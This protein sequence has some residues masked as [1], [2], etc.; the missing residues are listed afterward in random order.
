MWFVLFHPHV[1]H[2]H[3]LKLISVQKSLK[4]NIARIVMVGVKLSRLLLLSFA[5]ALLTSGL[6]DAQAPVQPQMVAQVMPQLAATN[7]PHF[8]FFHIPR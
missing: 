4:K 6:A 2:E 1:P 8:V 7:K 5:F 3:S